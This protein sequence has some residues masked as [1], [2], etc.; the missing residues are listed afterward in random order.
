MY[1]SVKETC[2]RRICVKLHLEKA[3]TLLLLYY[4]KKQKTTKCTKFNIFLYKML[5]IVIE[6]VYFE[7][8]FLYPTIYGTLINIDE[9]A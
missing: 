1:K 9:G 5:Y 7:H 2:E 6:V 3:L 4:S 8:T